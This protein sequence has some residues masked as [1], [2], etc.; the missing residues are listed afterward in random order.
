M[1]H[2]FPVLLTNSENHFFLSFNNFWLTLAP[3]LGLASSINF[4]NVVPYRS[5]LVDSG[6]VVKVTR[7]ND[8]YNPLISALPLD[9]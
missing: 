5:V 8:H 2:F 9:N 3:D 1:L 7:P 4:G 6:S